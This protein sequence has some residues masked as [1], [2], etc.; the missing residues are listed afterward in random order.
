M[1]AVLRAVDEGCYSL[2]GEVTADTVPGLWPQIVAIAGKGGAAQVSCA[3]VTRADSAAVAC[4]VEWARAARGA[5][6]SL[7][8]RDLPEVMKVIMDVSDL[9]GILAGAPIT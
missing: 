8:V 1:N 9:D 2:E 6:G 7:Q 4:L 5:G 3:G